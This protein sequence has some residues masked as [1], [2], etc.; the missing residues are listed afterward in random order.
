[1]F[2]TPAAVPG[3]APF[4]G[5]KLSE[6]SPSFAWELLLAASD[7]KPGSGKEAKK[8]AILMFRDLILH[9]REG[10]FVG[11]DLSAKNGYPTDWEAAV[12]WVKSRAAPRPTGEFTLFLMGG[13]V[14]RAVEGSPVLDGWK[15]IRLAFPSNAY[16]AKNAEKLNEE[17]DTGIRVIRDLMEKSGVHLD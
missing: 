12:N 7:M 15:V 5:T 14:A 6:F 11:F 16:D 13:V 17:F 2:L 10:L 9:K 4:T 8:K 3:K 1:M